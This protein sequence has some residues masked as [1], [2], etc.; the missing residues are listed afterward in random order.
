M[1]ACSDN[2]S[3]EPE[4]AEK[5]LKSLMARWEADRASQRHHAKIQGVLSICTLLLSG[6]GVGI[7]LNLLNH[8]VTLFGLPLVMSCGVFFLIGAGSFL[9]YRENFV[10]RAS[11][12]DEMHK[13]RD[14]RT[15]PHELEAYER[16]E[17]KD[18]ANSVALTL[19]LLKLKP[20]DARWIKPYLCTIAGLLG[21]HRLRDV[22]SDHQWLN[23]VLAAITALKNVG[24]VSVMPIVEKVANL[25]PHT[26]NGQKVVRFAEDCLQTLRSRA[27]QTTVSQTL[28]RPL[29]SQDE[30]GELL[31]AARDTEQHPDELLRISSLDP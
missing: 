9:K 15:L 30:A 16:F 21:A 27:E 12:L 11:I 31:R 8:H 7:G 13:L 14:I 1:P 3:Q 18:E 2:S 17:G 20:S 23:L 4:A 22:S 29:N 19:L 26:E 6:I 5:Y 28:L 24:D 25:R 10:S